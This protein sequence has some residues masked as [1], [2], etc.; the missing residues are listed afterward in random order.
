MVSDVNDAVTGI[1]DIT[2]TSEEQAHVTNRITSEVHSINEGMVPVRLAVADLSMLAEESDHA[3]ASIAGETQKI[4][5]M[6]EDIEDLTG[7][8]K[9]G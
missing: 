1:A 4:K 2:R 6:V 7:S 3:T 9:T 8:F 5:G